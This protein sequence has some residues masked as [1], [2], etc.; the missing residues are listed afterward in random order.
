MAQALQ[1]PAETPLDFSAA[2]L[3][4][5]TRAKLASTAR[6]GSTD[7]LRVVHLGDSWSQ[8]EGVTDGD[9]ATPSTYLGVRRL[10]EKQLGK[11]GW[12][13]LNASPNGTMPAPLYG[14][15]TNTTTGTWTSLS[16]NQHQSIGGVAQ[17]DYQYVGPNNQRLD[18]V[19]NG[20]TLVI[21]GIPPGTS[22][23]LSTS[24][25]A[26]YLVV[27]Y[28]KGPATPAAQGSL[29]H[30]AFSW[31]VTG[32]ASGGP[33]STVSANYDLGVLVIPVATPFYPT[34][35]ITHDAT[36]SLLSILAVEFVLTDPGVRFEN[37]ACSGNRV[38]DFLSADATFQEKSLA[39]LNPDLTILMFGTN[40]GNSGGYTAAQYQQYLA[41]LVNRVRAAQ[42]ISVQIAVLSDLPASGSFTLSVGGTSVGPIAVDGSGWSTT[43]TNANIQAALD[44]AFHGDS[45]LGAVGPAHSVV[46][47]ALGA[48]RSLVLVFQGAQFRGPN[49]SPVA[50]TWTANTLLNGSSRAITAAA[51][52]MLATCA[53]DVMLVSP[54]NNPLPAP[55]YPGSTDQLNYRNATAAV[56]RQLKCAYVDGYTLMGDL[57]QAIYHGVLDNGTGDHPGMNGGQILADAI[58][59]AI[60]GR[61]TTLQAMATYRGN[62]VFETANT[63][64]QNNNCVIIAPPPSTVGGIIIQ[65]YTTYDFPIGQTAPSKYMSLTY[66]NAKTGTSPG[67]NAA[68]NLIV[69]SGGMNV[70]CNNGNGYY[71]VEANPCFFGNNFARPGCQGCFQS[72]TGGFCV[73]IMSGAQMQA[74]SVAYPNSGNA[75]NDLKNN[76]NGMLIYVPDSV[77]VAPGL[78]MWCG[79]STHLSGKWNLISRKQ[80]ARI[81]HGQLYAP[82]RVRG[83]RRTDDRQSTGTIARRQGRGV[84]SGHHDQLLRGR[85][86]RDQQ[87]LCLDRLARAGHHGLRGVFQHGLS[88][89]DLR[90][91][92]DQSG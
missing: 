27:Y 64:L 17:D 87:H 15:I 79:D 89:H 31:A 83:S 14:S 38:L 8:M 57:G 69:S 86:R 5:N 82:F 16:A 25:A 33:V 41:Q 52:E 92:T 34:L 54:C 39:A 55:E 26:A 61:D 29:A 67:V 45:I 51:T 80:P 10:L 76:S 88:G 28:V 43:A 53:T 56:A 91:R 36:S 58:Y 75:A 19:G 23:S 37:Y 66:D 20:A 18:S 70:I 65:E 24:G 62:I 49:W 9:P 84:G 74:I 77:T 81:G 73:P 68:A 85:R 71:F 63:H 22:G 60:T 13:I 1:L 12:G 3:L 35:T 42:M 21:K 46:G 32:G 72:T 30:A 50:F 44:A 6:A 90:S 59:R 4:P 2:N 47:Y 7:Q 11:A 78:Y 48:C 40:D